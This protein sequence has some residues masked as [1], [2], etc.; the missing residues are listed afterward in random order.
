MVSSPGPMFTL[1]VISG[2][3]NGATRNGGCFVKCIV[4]YHVL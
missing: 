4:G 3:A 2:S 1:V